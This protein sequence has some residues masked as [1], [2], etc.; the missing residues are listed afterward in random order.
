MSSLLGNIDVSR[1]RF[2]R[3]GG[4]GEPRFFGGFDVSGGRMLPAAFH[5]HVKSGVPVAELQEAP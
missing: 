3:V 1:H 4:A 2:G 5:P